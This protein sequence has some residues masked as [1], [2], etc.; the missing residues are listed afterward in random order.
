MALAQQVRRRAPGLAPARIADVSRTRAGAGRAVA[1]STASLA[2]A[3]EAEGGTIAVRLVLG[4][5]MSAAGLRPRD[6]RRRGC[7]RLCRAAAGRW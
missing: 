7:T 2:R 4:L 3:L 1:D 6:C 5:E